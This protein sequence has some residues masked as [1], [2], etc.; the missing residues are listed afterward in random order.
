MRAGTSKPISRATRSAASSCS[1]RTQ[2][3]NQLGASG[4]EFRFLV[5]YFWRVT[6]AA[7]L[8]ALQYSTAPVQLFVSLSRLFH[9]AS[10]SPRQSHDEHPDGSGAHEL[11]S[12][13]WPTADRMQYGVAEL[14]VLP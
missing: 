6:V 14:H 8:C 9:A 3:P 1:G 11:P 5:F 10:T 4:P 12:V 2:V 7:P 13:T